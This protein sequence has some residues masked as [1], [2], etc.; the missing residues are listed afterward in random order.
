MTGAE[1]QSVEEQFSGTDSETGND[2]SVTPE[3]TSA[4]SGTTAGA[5]QDAV[6]ATAASEG[7]ANEAHHAAEQAED[8]ADE[9]AQLE[10]MVDQIEGELIEAYDA[11]NSDDDDDDDEVIVQTSGTEAGGTETVV[12]TAANST[13]ACESEADSNLTGQ[14]DNT[15]GAGTSVVNEASGSDT[16][17]VA[18]NTATTTGQAN[19]TSTPGTCNDDMATNYLMEGDCTYPVCGCPDPQAANWNN[20][21]TT[22][23][24]ADCTPGC[25]YD[26]GAG[27][28]RRRLQAEWSARLG[29]FRRL[30]DHEDEGNSTS[31]STNGKEAVKGLKMDREM[32]KEALRRES[33][34]VCKMKSSK[35][36][37][38]E[39]YAQI[40]LRA[41]DLLSLQEP[42]LK[43]FGDRLKESG[44]KPFTY[45]VNVYEDSEDGDPDDEDSDEDSDGED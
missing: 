5:Y 32:V 4:A 21:T 30:L 29:A 43:I 8:E 3:D 26:T 2:Q 10:E 38:S 34:K 1:Q 31:N 41:K 6:N 11:A 20:L 9:Q 39:A 45:T 22:P 28:N 13:V 23:L 7:A 19:N 42:L 12:C 18:T 25:V 35:I 40:W 17:Y 14:D 27:A 15:S 24:P 37:Q 44:E 16:T 33:P 36:C